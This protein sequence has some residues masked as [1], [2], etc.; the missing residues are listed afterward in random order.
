MNSLPTIQRVSPDTLEKQW[1]DI[2]EILKNT[3]INMILVSE[4]IGAL[5][6]V[7][8]KGGYGT[9]SISIVGGFVQEFKVTQ[10]RRLTENI[11]Q[12]TEKITIL[13]IE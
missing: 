11:I 4:L 9:I 12:D 5:L 2:K 6:Q 7:T 8:D 13:D 1:D 3:N 10:S